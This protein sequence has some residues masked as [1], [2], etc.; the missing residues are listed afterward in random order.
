MNEDQ[1]AS[2]R[3]TNP[4]PGA[5]AGNQ[6]PRNWT[7]SPVTVTAT[8]TGGVI[9][10]GTIAIVLIIALLRTLARNRKLE[11]QLAQRS[12]VA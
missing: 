5:S 10:L 9:F 1:F 3:E 2:P 6:N 8:E 4:N 7:F 12:P 11:I